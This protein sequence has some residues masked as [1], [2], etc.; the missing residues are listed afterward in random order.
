MDI[1]FRAEQAVVDGVVR[2]AAVGVAG[3]VIEAVGPIDAEYEAVREIVLPTGSVLLP[4]LV[5]THVHINEPGTDWEGFAAATAAAAAGGVTTL[6]D[7]PLDCDPVT[8]N[9]AALAVKRDAARGSCQVDV[10]FWGGVVPDNVD[11]LHELAAAGAVGFKCFLSESG[12][13]NF[14]PLAPEDFERAMERIA[15]LGSV[16]LVHAETHRVINASPPPKGRT[17]SSFLLS[18]PDAAEEE[19]VGLV[20]DAA[21]RTGARTHVVH[22]SSAR[23]LPMLEAAKAAGLPVT[24]ET[25]P[26]YLTFAAEDI[27]DGATE[28]AACPPIRSV[29]NRDALWDGLCD[30]TLDMIVS[31][32]SPCAPALKAGGDFGRVFGGISSLELGLRAVWTQARRRGYRL[33]DV[34]RWM[35]QRPADL[36]GFADRARIAVGYRADLCVFDPDAEHAVRAGDLSHR[37]PITPYDGVVL[38]GA[39]VQTWLRGTLV[40]DRVGLAA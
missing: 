37:H 10:E 22:V 21:R 18:R 16:L 27:A 17:Y 1:V 35:A 31:D 30:G 38:R 23:V 5:D 24:A 19:A 40:H 8:T 6:V 11:S 34:C 36:A 12:N 15:E 4:G 28:F 33:A 29:H 32:H 9:A 26:H 20:I 7:M 25:C 2:A 13:P 39:V 3:G 14:P